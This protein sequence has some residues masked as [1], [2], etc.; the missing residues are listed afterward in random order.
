VQTRTRELIRQSVPKDQFLSRL[1]TDDLGW[2]LG[3]DT[4]F[5]R[6]AAG[7]FYD[8]LATAR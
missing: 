3:A 6:N 5:V 7:G 4:L 1:K 2:A 8:R